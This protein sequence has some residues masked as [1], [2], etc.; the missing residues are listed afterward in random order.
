MLLNFQLMGDRFLYLPKD[1]LNGHGH[2]DI[3]LHTEE[4]KKMAKSQK[5]AQDNWALDLQ[6]SHCPQSGWFSSVHQPCSVKLSFPETS[7]PSS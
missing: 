7:V 1:L 3:G 2:K 5:V 6:P 4:G